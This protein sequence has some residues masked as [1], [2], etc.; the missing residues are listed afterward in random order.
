MNGMVGGWER[1]RQTYQVAPFLHRKAQA[2]KRAHSHTIHFGQN[3]VSHLM[4]QRNGFSIRETKTRAA[5]DEKIGR[6]FHIQTVAFLVFWG[7][8]GGWV[9]WFGWV[10]GLTYLHR[11]TRGKGR[12][13]SCG[14]G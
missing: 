7:W 5:V 2:T 10:G 8:V 12:T 11:T 1:E 6:A 9:G 4:G 3:R 13:C 14:P